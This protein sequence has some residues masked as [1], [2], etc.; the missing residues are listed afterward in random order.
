MKYVLCINILHYITIQPYVRGTDLESTNSYWSSQI[1]SNQIK[2]ST[3]PLY[4][5]SIWDLEWGGMEKIVSH[6]P[7]Y[8]YSVYTIHFGP[9]SQ[10]TRQGTPRAMRTH[11]FYHAPLRI[12]NGIAPRPA[13]V[14][15]LSTRSIRVIIA[16]LEEKI[17]IIIFPWHMSEEYIWK[18]SKVIYARKLVIMSILSC[19]AIIEI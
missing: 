7:T 11:F 2:S 6:P 14:Y 3:V 15:C 18:S 4:G 5:Y 13:A 1:K 10:Q 16:L 17:K 12:S 19:W 8:F 9:P